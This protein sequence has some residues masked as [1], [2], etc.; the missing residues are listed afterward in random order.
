[1]SQLFYPQQIDNQLSA[2]EIHI[3]CTSLELPVSRFQNMLSFDEKARAERYHSQDDA[4]R[5]II[6]RG[7][8]RTLLG[9]YLDVEPGQI[10]FCYGKNG[11]PG[12]VDQPSRAEIYFNLA[13]TDNL[14][15]YGF[16]RDNEIGVDIEYIKDIPEMERIVEIYFTAG[17]REIFHTLPESKKNEVFFNCWTRKE[18]IVK[19]IGD[20]VSWPLDEVDVLTVPAE[21]NSLQEIEGDMKVASRWSVQGLKPAAGC[22]AAIAVDGPIWRVSCWQWPG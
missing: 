2:S 1:M 10:Q 3:W 5:F 7:M 18:A 11:K 20:G 17:E 21:P 9:Y 22:S 8:L 19:M 13:H 15:L 16:T 12:I 14:A 6:R 4:N